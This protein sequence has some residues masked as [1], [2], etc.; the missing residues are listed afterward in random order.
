MASFCRKFGTSSIT[1]KERG[2]MI[3]VAL[4]FLSSVTNSSQYFPAD[5]AHFSVIEL[6]IDQNKINF[7][8][9]IVG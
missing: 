3:P 6:G 5:L 4:C 9:S 8:K 7:L 1:K 2:V